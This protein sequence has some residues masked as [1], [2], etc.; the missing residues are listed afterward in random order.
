MFV[1]PRE[2]PSKTPLVSNS[3]EK[4]LQWCRERG[5]GHIETSAKDGTGVQAAMEVR[6]PTGSQGLMTAK[7]T[8]D[9]K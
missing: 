3:A 8:S 1:P 7:N 4:V 6:D 5:I 9:P 2:V